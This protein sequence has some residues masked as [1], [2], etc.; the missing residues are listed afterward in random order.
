VPTLKPSKNIKI[1]IHRTIIVIVVLYG[2]ETW[3]LT[4]LEEYGQRI[5][6]KFG[7]KRDDVTRECR[8]LQNEELYD[9]Y[10]SLDHGPGYLSRYSD[11][12][13]T[14]RPGDRFPVE[15][16]IF[17]SRAD[18]PWGLAHPAYCTMGTG[19]FPGVRRPGNGDDHPSSSAEVKESIKLY[20]YSSLWAF[21]A[22]FRVTFTF[23]FHYILFR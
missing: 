18:R 5:F 19:S 9:L 4:L 12:L 13:R 2:C 3:S 8:R 1:T 20:L 6:E 23:T 22:C 21:V 7:P 11:S 10:S 17:R 16:E 15:D 14:G